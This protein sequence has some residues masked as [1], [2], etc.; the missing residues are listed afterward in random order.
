[1]WAIFQGVLWR[2]LQHC[3]HRDDLCLS[4]VR[5]Q[6]LYFWLGRRFILFD[7]SSCVSA[8]PKGCFYV[9]IEPSFFHFQIRYPFDWRTPSKY[10][11]A[12]LSQI[13]GGLALLST[14]IPFF[15]IFAASCWLFMF[16]AEDITD[17]LTN[18]N[19]DDAESGTVERLIR[20]RGIIQTYTDAKQYVFE[21]VEFGN[22]N[23]D[24]DSLICSQVCCE[25]HW[26]LCGLAACAF[27]DH[28]FGRLLH[29]PSNRIRIS[30]VLYLIEI[31]RVSFLN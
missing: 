2:L 15:G 29:T 28:P 12:F 1:M 19:R 10:P 17:N 20:F 25:F 22:N 26:I 6:L 16:I 7:F 4:F 23:A 11:L 30:W 13:S 21:C 3:L 9:S 27:F 24:N 18:F 5:C 8:E 31:L 14:A